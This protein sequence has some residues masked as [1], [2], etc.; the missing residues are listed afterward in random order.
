MSNEHWFDG[1]R[2]RVGALGF[3]DWL[4]LALAVLVPTVLAHYGTLDGSS[5]VGHSDISPGRKTDPAP[6]FDWNKY[7]SLLAGTGE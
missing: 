2:A 5:I 3:G 7:R 6:A 4:G 1:W